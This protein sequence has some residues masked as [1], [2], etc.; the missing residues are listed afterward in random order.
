MTGD[1]LVRQ[2]KTDG[3]ESLG[4]FLSRYQGRVYD[5]N[6]P[7]KQFRVKV[8][9]ERVLGKQVS[10]WA[11]PVGIPTGKGMG[12]KFPVKK[13]DTVW[14]S[15]QGGDPNYPLWEYGPDTKNNAVNGGEG[16]YTLKTHAGQTIVLNDKEGSVTVTNKAGYTVVIE[17]TGVGIGKG[18]AKHF[19]PLGDKTNELLQEFIQLVSTATAGGFPLTTAANIAAL[20]PKLQTILSKK[21]YILE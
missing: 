17:K 19:V 13:G 9:C 15:F 18:S 20:V 6:D 14:V 10:Q 3:L 2:I 1:E 8:E 21:V 7:N 4:I 11:L 12:I 5:S 16:V